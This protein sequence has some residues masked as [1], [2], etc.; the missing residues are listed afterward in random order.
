MAKAI[1]KTNK[2]EFNILDSA[3][4]LKKGSAV[5]EVGFLP[6]D[7]DT[8]KNGA[9]VV[10]A[11]LFNEFGTEN[12]DGSKRIPA[13]PFMRRTATDRRRDLNKLRL[14]LMKGILNEKLTL[15]DALNALG[16][17][18]AAWIKNTINRTEFTPNAASTIR[19]KGE[20]KRPLVDTG[21]MRRSVSWQVG[22]K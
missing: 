10:E 14:G 11:A 3:K 5:V 19:K 13:R 21:K 6:G 12:P 18:Y 4:R 9:S 2:K 22:R 1:F 7:D 15:N 17:K 16:A 8:Y 20:G